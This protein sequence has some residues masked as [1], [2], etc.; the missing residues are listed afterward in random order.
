MVYSPKVEEFFSRE[1]DTEILYYVPEL[2]QRMLSAIER[3]PPPHPDDWMPPNKWFYD[4]DPNDKKKKN[5]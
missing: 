4:P 1:E 3:S 5:N 2:K